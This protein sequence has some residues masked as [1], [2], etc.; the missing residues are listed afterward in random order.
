MK[1]EDMKEKSGDEVPFKG[2][3]SDQVGQGS[4]Q[5][6]PDEL[7]EGEKEPEVIQK[8]RQESKARGE[9]GG[10]GPVQKPSSDA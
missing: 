1:T 8:L 5:D 2:V 7:G 10:T 9:E 3:P 6:P 4:G